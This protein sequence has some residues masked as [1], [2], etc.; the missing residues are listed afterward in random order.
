ML[1][2]RRRSNEVVG[3]VNF[4]VGQPGWHNSG[5]GGMFVRLVVEDLEDYDQKWPPCSGGYHQVIMDECFQGDDVNPDPPPHPSME[6]MDRM[7]KEQLRKLT[8]KNEFPAEEYHFPGLKEKH[9]EQ[10]LSRYASISYLA[11]INLGATG[12]SGYHK[13]K[14][15][16]RCTYNDLTSEGKALYDNLKALYPGRKLFLQTWLDT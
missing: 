7:T 11:I 12:W 10:G 2:S 9:E 5:E 6:E 3:F 13:E 1:P 14:G 4:P 16:F 15:Y 8:L